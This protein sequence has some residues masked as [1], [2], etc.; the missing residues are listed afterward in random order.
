MVSGAMFMAMI[1][2]SVNPG[3]SVTALLFCMLLFAH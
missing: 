2:D 3:S 1:R